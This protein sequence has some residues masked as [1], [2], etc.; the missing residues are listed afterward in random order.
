MAQQVRRRGRATKVDVF[1]QQIGSDDCFFARRAA[2]DSGV[3]SDACNDRLS[4]D[5][6]A[7]AKCS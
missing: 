7:L 5:A 6:D 3:V 2:K 4:G 1:N